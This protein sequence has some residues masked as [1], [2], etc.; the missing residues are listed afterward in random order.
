L[1]EGFVRLMNQDDVIGP[2]NIGNPGE[3]TILELAQKVIAQTGSKSKII[4][5]ALPLD[6]PKQRQPDITQAR[7]VLGW[8]PTVS[9]DEGLKPTIA[10]FDKV[11]SEG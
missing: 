7:K 4:H 6:D 9:L 10:Y 3:F 5:E 2:M 11:L 8:E 1:I